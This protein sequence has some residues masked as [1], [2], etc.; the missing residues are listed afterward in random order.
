MN[1]SE[2]CSAEESACLRLFPG[3]ILQPFRSSAP[4]NSN[5]LLCKWETHVI[6]VKIDSRTGNQCQD[7]CKLLSKLTLTSNWLE[8]STVL[9]SFVTLTR[10]NQWSLKRGGTANKHS[11]YS[12][13]ATWLC[14]FPCNVNS[15]RFVKTWL[16]P[17]KIDAIANKQL[18]LTKEKD[19]KKLRNPTVK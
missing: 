7:E 11:S 19:R 14:N 9:S 13:P 3:Y 18:L 10:N 6:K 12:L 15:F 1:V 5:Q 17:I 16:M 8:F 4:M 2:A